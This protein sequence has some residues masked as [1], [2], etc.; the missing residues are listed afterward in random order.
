MKAR[1]SSLRRIA[2]LWSLLTILIVTGFPYATNLF[3]EARFRTFND[4]RGRVEGLLDRAGEETTLQEWEDSVRTGRDAL[5]GE[6][7]REA[8][9]AIEEE[10]REHG[11]T[12]ELRNELT[13]K[14]DSA[15]ASWESALAD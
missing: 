6:W 1:I 3:S 12:P 2:V 13:V 14:R 7:E 5:R 8:D 9:R 15:R 10:L 4:D 11:D